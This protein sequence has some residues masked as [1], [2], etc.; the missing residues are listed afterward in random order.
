[1]GHSRPASGSLRGA[2]SWTDSDPAP[3]P[4]AELLAV[5]SAARGVVVAAGG[6]VELA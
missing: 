4:G 2:L 1:M 5:V 3:V 6:V